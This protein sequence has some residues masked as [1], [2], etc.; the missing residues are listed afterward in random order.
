MMFVSLMPLASVLYAFRESNLSGKVI[1]VILFASSIFV[2]SI[3]V[4]K[5][6]ELR[7]A[8]EFSHRFLSAYRREAHPISLYL[9]R[10]RFDATP[11]YDIY[12]KGSLHGCHKFLRKIISLNLQLANTIGHHVITDG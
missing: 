8:K 5:Y 12:E 11:L 1:V 6:T 4:T 2:W 9:K 7:R 10:Q 3:M